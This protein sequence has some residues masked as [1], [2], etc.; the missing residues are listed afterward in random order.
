MRQHSDASVRLSAISASRP[1]VRAAWP[2]VDVP[3]TVKPAAS[4]HSRAADR[5]VVLPAPAT[6]TMSSAPRPD[7]STSSMAARWPAVKEW[8]IACSRAAMAAV[9]ASRDTAGASVRATWRSTAA[10]MAC[11][12]AMVVAV[13]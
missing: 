1:R 3:I 9:A 5:A 13:A 11:S 8:P 2:D 4:K 6:P 12:R 10:A 7:V